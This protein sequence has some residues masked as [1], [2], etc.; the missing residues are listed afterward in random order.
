M[1]RK[2]KEKTTQRKKNSCIDREKERLGQ[3]EK[4]NRK[5]KNVVFRQW[6]ESDKRAL[7]LDRV[8]D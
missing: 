5:R 6:K 8:R 7:V 3:I 2:E 4:G 1:N